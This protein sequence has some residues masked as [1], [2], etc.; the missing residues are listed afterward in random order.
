MWNTAP[1]R[2]G[3]DRISDVLSRPGG[4]DGWVVWAPRTTKRVRLFGSSWMCAATACRPK[5]CAARSPAIAATVASSEAMRAASP[6]LATACRSTDGQ[7]WL[8]QPVHCASAWEWAQIRV[9]RSMDPDRVSRLWWTGTDT[10]PSTRSG[11]ASSRSSVRLTA[12][13]DEFSTGTMPKSAPPASVARNTSSIVVHGSPFTPMPNCFCIAASEK[14]PDG[15]RKATV[16]SRSSARQADITS[17]KMFDSA[18]SPSGPA[19]FAATLR[20][21]SASRSGRNT[22]A[23]TSCLMRP[24]AL[25]TRARSFSS[26]TSLPS[27]ASMASRSGLRR[28]SRESAMAALEVIHEI[29]QRAHAF[30]GHGV[31]DRR[32]HAADQPVALQLDQALLPGLLQESVIQLRIGEGER[33]VHARTIAPVDPVRVEAGAIDRVV[34]QRRLLDVPALDGRDASLRLEPFQDQ[35]RDVDGIRRRRVV[36]RVR[37]GV[38]PVVEHRRPARRAAADQVVAHDHQ[39]QPGRPEVLLRAGVD[40][41]EL[42]H[43]ERTRQEV[44]RHVGDEG[45]VAR[46]RDVGEL[47]PVDGLVGAVVDERGRGVELQLGLA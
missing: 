8:S 7:C 17:R 30:D 28:S 19:L 20:S 12:P 9:T 11:V 26:S 22:G 34:Q 24:T 5:R 21:T 46:V 44:R 47:Q 6:L 2:F 13:S 32:P 33:H 3:T 38:R 14:V 15:P 29:D 43:V 36:H 16:S 25:A 42:G 18:T 1:A 39:R 23:P 41:A 40:D 10:S 45:D 31:V 4:A 27:M 35:V 37:L